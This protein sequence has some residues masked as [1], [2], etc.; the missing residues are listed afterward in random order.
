M[1]IDFFKSDNHRAIFILPVFVIGFWVFSFINVEY[2]SISVDMLL[3]EQVQNLFSNSYVSRVLAMFLIFIEAILLNKVVMSKKVYSKNSYLPALL[4]VVLM[5][6][7]PAMLYLNPIIIA[8][9]FLILALSKMFNIDTEDGFLPNVFD[10]SVLIG[11]ASIIYFPAIIF[12]MF[13][14]YCL[15]FLRRSNLR[16]R[17]ICVIGVAIPFAFLLCYYFWI[18]GIERFWFDI[19]WNPIY[20]KQQFHINESQYYVPIAILFFMTVMSFRKLYRG[21]SSSSINTKRILSV[22]IG[23]FIFSVASIFLAQSYSIK[24]FLFLAIPLSIYFTNF[25]L[26]AKRKWLSEIIFVLLICSLI[27]NHISGI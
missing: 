5:S 9:L 10:A 4:Y 8:N 7:F 15:V 2:N 20:H 6:S 18:E 12:S 22:L 23:F 14:M 17:L 11:I 25:F 3:Y 1:I 27:Y 13:I 24:Y 16:E 19:V 21:L 26:F